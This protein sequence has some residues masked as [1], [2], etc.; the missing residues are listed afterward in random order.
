MTLTS[1][2]SEMSGTSGDENEDMDMTDDEVLG[3]ENDSNDSA[4]DQF[5]KSKMRNGIE[6]SLVPDEENKEV[7][8]ASGNEP[9]P[10]TDELPD[11]HEMDDIESPLYTMHVEC[12]IDEDGV[13][14]QKLNHSDD[15][16]EDIADA[17]TAKK[18]KVVEAPPERIADAVTSVETVNT[19]ASSPKDKSG[20]SDSDE[21]D[22]SAATALTKQDKQILGNSFFSNLD[23]FCKKKT[24]N[25]DEADSVSEHS[26]L[27]S[28]CEI[29]D[30]SMFKND[31]KDIDEAKMAKKMKATRKLAA[32]KAAVAD[33]CISLSSDSDL[34]L[35]EP[36]EGAEER[37]E[38]NRGPRRMLRADELAGETKQA[39][40][41]EADRV[42]R[43]EKKVERMTQLTQSQE[44]Q[45]L[46][47]ESDVVLD[48]DTKKETNITVH[49]EIVK[50]LKPH[51]VRSWK[52]CTCFTHY[53]IYS[54]CIN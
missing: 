44:S 6:S 48:I 35:E 2:D 53:N 25:I 11:D 24:F 22:T 30:I 26:S 5:L 32:T 39:Q 18:H 28:D 45:S 50:F 36:N 16:V 21:N 49:P 47:A 7:T 51:Q 1:S 33:D 40:R 34:D 46:I 8:S 13:E 9:P 41:E 20:H 12:I 31:H 37:T 29:L 23:E 15:V 4:I 10:T 27:S 17:A 14:K 42:K 43:L 3:D 38:K 19:V 54:L 52:I